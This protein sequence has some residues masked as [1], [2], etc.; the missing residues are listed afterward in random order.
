MLAV[1]ELQ[2]VG[3]RRQ[4]AHADADKVAVLAVGVVG[5]R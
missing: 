2:L 3:C 5:F 1:D 4:A